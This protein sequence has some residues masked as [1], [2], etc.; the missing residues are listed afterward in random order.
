MWLLPLWLQMGL[1]K[2][3]SLVRE[4][5]D[6]ASRELV[7]EQSLDKIQ[8]GFSSLMLVFVPFPESGFAGGGHCCCW[9]KKGGG[10]PG[11]MTYACFMSRGALC[12]GQHFCCVPCI[13]DAA[14][15]LVWHEGTKSRC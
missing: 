11:N 2:H 10:Q 7:I 4:V 8:Q 13:M 15:P 6:L 14:W 1:H 12:P 9:L 3:L 5:A